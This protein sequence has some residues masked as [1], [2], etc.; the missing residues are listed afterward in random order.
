[1]L[2]NLGD[3]QAPAPCKQIYR[4]RKEK[5]PSKQVLSLFIAGSNW[6]LQL[7]GCWTFAPIPKICRK[8][9][10]AALSARCCVRGAAICGA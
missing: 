10:A 3:F 1:M 4:G 8:I 2:G 9:I 6:L 7:L 5:N